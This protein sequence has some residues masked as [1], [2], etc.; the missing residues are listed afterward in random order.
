MKTN[1]EVKLGFV[2][3]KTRVAPKK[4]LSIPRLE[5]QAAVL[6]TRLAHTIKDETTRKLDSV[7]YWS[8]SQTVLGWIHS[9]HRRYSA[10]VSHRIGE[11]LTHST[12]HQ[13]RWVPS[14]LNVADD[15]TKWKETSPILDRWF[16]GPE[17]LLKPENEWPENKFGET[18]DE[19][20]LNVHVHVENREIENQ[21]IQIERFSKW[22]RLLRATGF[23]VRF[24][25]LVK[26]HKQN[27]S[28]RKIIQPCE[29]KQIYKKIPA[30]TDTELRAA[31]RILI[32]INQRESFPA[33]F[34]LLKQNKVVPKSSKIYQLSVFVD[35]G[36]MKLESRLDMAPPVV[37]QEL[38]NPLIL[39]SQHR[40]TYLMM[41]FLHRQFHHCARETVINEFRQK[42]WVTKIRPLLNHVINDCNLCKFMRAKPR[43]PRM[44]TL[45][46]QRLAPYE[47]P[48]TYTGMDYFGPLE[49]TVGRRHEKR[50]GVIFTCLTMRAIHLELAASLDT[51]ACVN[52]IRNFMN[53]RGQPKEILCDNGS[54]LKS[55]EKEL[56]N[57]V[58]DIEFDEIASRTQNHKPVG[59]F[60][61]FIYNPPGAPHFGG[62]W[63]R[64]V[65]LVKRC[66]Y[67][68]LK[69]KAPKE[70]VLRCALI[71]AEDMVNSRPLNYVT[72]LDDSLEAITPNHLL[73]LRARPVICPDTNEIDWRKTW[74]AAQ[75]LADA[76][77]K[78]FVA[79]YIPTIAK[80]S[81]WFD[82]EKPL[83]INQLVL[84]V[85]ENLKRGEWKRGIVT[86][87][88]PGR[89][90]RIRSATV[91]TAKS[92]YLRPVAKL[93]VIDVDACKE[94]I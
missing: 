53:R 25:N 48:F 7:T 43:V 89:D 39:G 46:Y 73:K 67:Q 35:D 50:Y 70:D 54:N 29:L 17:Y 12:I 8:D 9:S 78:R 62:S 86:E 47:A 13:W 15:A 4:S 42:F 59:Q 21:I 75:A 85:D 26:N 37:T 3:S 55:A 74:S 36:Q 71:E 77:W 68:I 44:A 41:E 90:G 87:V 93:A 34:E 64:M 79:E 28:S 60:T 81:K 94:F 20:V 45:P 61:K 65:G 19:E 76:F 52:C 84:I 16:D 56:K 10:F 91:K 22:E 27:Q 57:A 11:I 83:K 51:N 2:A 80:R 69:E 40:I 18:T 33:E 23:V 24:M 72:T 92:S 63:E 6:A 88:H 38:R 14:K 66:L 5:L 58:L 30:L 82:E 31:E 1:C 49:I 32:L